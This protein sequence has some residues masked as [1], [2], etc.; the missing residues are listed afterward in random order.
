MLIPERW[1]T[2]KRADN[3]LAA[4]IGRSV[5]STIALFKITWKRQCARQCNTRYPAAFRSVQP[6]LH[7]RPMPQSPIHCIAPPRSAQNFPLPKTAAGLP[8]NTWIYGSHPTH[9]QCISIESAVFPQ[10]TL[11]TVGTNTQ[12]DR[13]PY[14]QVVY[15]I[16]HSATRH[17]N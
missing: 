17:N 12:F 11:V 6:F 15:A 14:K 10:C 13:Y 8:S 16:P 9:H 1:R 5:L 7:V 3:W 4:C 2:A